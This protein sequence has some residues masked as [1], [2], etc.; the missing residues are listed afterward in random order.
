MLDLKIGLASSQP[1]EGKTLVA[2]LMN[3]MFS[4]VYGYSSG[5]YSLGYSL[6]RELSELLGITVEQVEELKEAGQLEQDYID[7]VSARFRDADQELFGRW[8][9]LPTKSMRALLQLW[10]TEYRRNQSDSYWIDNWI[11][12]YSSCSLKI[13]DDIRFIDDMNFCDLVIYVRNNNSHKYRG[14]VDNHKS[15]D[16][17]FKKEAY[18][19]ADYHITNSYPPNINEGI[20]SS[21][22][23]QARIISNYDFMSVIDG[24]CRDIITNYE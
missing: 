4:E 16:P 12:R 7:V 2:S 20:S 8:L 5:I 15:E 1:K 13:I 17:A 6:K 24:V 14:G 19:R 10:G 21:K 22:I 9:S 18:S 23:T 11:G 3:Y